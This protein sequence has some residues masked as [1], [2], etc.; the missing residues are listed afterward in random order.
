MIASTILNEVP[1][2]KPKCNPPGIKQESANHTL[3]DKICQAHSS[4]HPHIIPKRR[5]LTF[6]I[7]PKQ[8]IAHTDRRRHI[9]I[10]PQWNIAN[11]NHCY[12]Q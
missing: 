10:H 7:N 11:S 1:R 8:Q 2:V 9:I 12:I 6:V 3:T 4:V 5:I